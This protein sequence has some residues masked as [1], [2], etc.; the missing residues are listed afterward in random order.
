MAVPEEVRVGSKGEALPVPHTLGVGVVE[1]V[2]AE[3]RVGPLAG[4]DKEGSTV[5]VRLS[6]EPGVDDPRVE[7]LRE[8]VGSTVVEC[9]ALKHALPTGTLTKGLLVVDTLAAA[10]GDAVEASEA[11]AML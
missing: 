4:G 11:E 3:V 7:E 2:G 1:G 6:M 8:G 10:A 9:V 5:T